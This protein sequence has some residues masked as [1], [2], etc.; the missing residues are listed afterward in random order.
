[1]SSGRWHVTAIHHTPPNPGVLQVRPP[2]PARAAV[3]ST[4]T[5][6]AG[7]GRGWGNNKLSS[8]RWHVTAIHHTP[9]NPGGRYQLGVRRFRRLPMRSVPTFDPNG[10][11]PAL[12]DV[13]EESASVWSIDFQKTRT[14]VWESFVCGN[15]PLRIGCGDSAAW[16]DGGSAA[17]QVGSRRAQSLT[18]WSRGL[19]DDSTLNRVYHRP[20][21]PP[22]SA[23]RARSPPGRG[24]R[25]VARRIG[26]G[27][28]SA[29]AG[30]GR[31]RCRG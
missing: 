9:P 31:L 13:L 16:E 11:A 6:V 14:L 2:S 28:L 8:G 25:A 20:C 10:H 17:L 30:L 23:L 21:A 5:V 7:E 19:A 1:L 4:N 18:V 24:E 27:P 15:P 12:T 26:E 3:P 29:R 22:S